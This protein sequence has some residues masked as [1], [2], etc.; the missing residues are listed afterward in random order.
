MLF[1]KHQFERAPCLSTVLTPAIRN[2][3]NTIAIIAVLLPLVVTAQDELE[4]TNSVLTNHVADCAA[5]VGPYHSQVKDHANNQHV[6]GILTISLEKDSCTFK[7]NQI[8]NHDFGQNA[9]WP[10]SPA[11]NIESLQIPRHPTLADK[12]APVGLN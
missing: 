7:I 5:Y 10:H 2:W 1:A 9:R 8:P 4:I 11:P 3:L 6:E 12:P